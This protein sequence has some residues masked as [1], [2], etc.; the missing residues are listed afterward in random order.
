MGQ[1]ALVVEAIQAGAKSYDEVG[2]DGLASL[3][4]MCLGPILSY[5]DLAGMG[6]ASRTT[7]DGIAGRIMLDP[8]HLYAIAAPVTAATP[9]VIRLIDLRSERRR[10]SRSPRR[11]EPE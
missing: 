11:G 3:R 9:I 4:T 6:N 7:P 10:R 5:A 1:Q 2:A 8:Q